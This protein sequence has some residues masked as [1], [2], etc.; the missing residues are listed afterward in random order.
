MR[1]PII[2]IDGPSGVGKSTLSKL[3]A[4]ELGF[5]NLDTGAMYRAVALA[6]VQH[7]VD[8]DDDAALGRLAETVVV[9]FDRDAGT[10][11]VLLDGEDVSAAIRTPEI[12]LLTSK[13]SACPAVREALVRRQRELGIR[14]GF[15]LEGRDI[16]T[17]VFPD[18]EVKFFLVASA[19]ERGRRRFLELQAK[20]VAVDLAKTVAEVEARDAADSGRTHSPLRRAADAVAI[21]TT[22]RGIDQVLAE[23]LQ[24][25]RSRQSAANSGKE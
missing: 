8:P 18:A 10:E 1:K 17:V 20:G 23:M 7:G 5:V 25:V 4:R 19:A 22:A 15:V 24:V 14:G 21:D 6:A 13:V 12:S 16:G 2:A 11:R 3:L 9:D